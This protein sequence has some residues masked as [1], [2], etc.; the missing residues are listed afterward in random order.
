MTLLVRCA[1]PL[2]LL[3]TLASATPARADA[4]DAVLAAHRASMDAR[5]RVEMTSSTGG[6]QARTTVLYDTSQRVHM[7]S[8]QME[9]ILLPEGAWM[10]NGNGG[11]MKPPFDVGGI[12]RQ[13]VPETVE[14][15]QKGISNVVDEGRTTFEGTPV[16]AY[17]FD[18]A[19]TVMG[20]AVSSH[21]RILVA[22]DGR[23][24][25]SVSDGEALG[26]KT[27]SEQI[28]HYD[29]AIRVVAPQ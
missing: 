21:S 8:E 29:D 14:Q 26:K 4:R 28:Y 3:L 19:M 16:H 17:R 7:K 18:V 23:I 6:R 24:A 20:I 1:A 10:R 2:L 22:A 15:M 12:V 11:W 9:I 5:V 25:Q 27:H 13:L